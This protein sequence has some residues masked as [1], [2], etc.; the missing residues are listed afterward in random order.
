MGKP[1]LL[2]IPGMMC[3][4]RL[5]A[6]QV[7]RFAGDYDVRIAPTTGHRTIE[8]LAGAAIAVLD[9]TPAI[10]AGLS[11]GGIIAM[12][13]MRQAPH[14]VERLI[15]LDTNARADLESRRPVRERQIAEVEAGRLREVFDAELMPNYLARGNETDMELRAVLTQMAMDLGPETFIDQSVALRDRRSYEDLLPSINVPVLVVCGTEDRVC[16]PL[17]HEEIAG[18]CPEGELNLVTGAGHIST[19]ERPDKVNDIIARFLG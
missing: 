15:L 7:E 10:V 5:F 8:G 9:D 11:M 14:L 18:R 19:L 12:E 6:P 16:R 1:I 13:V 2:L 4:G 17:L 3:D